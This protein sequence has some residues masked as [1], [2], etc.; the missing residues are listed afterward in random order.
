MPKYSEARK[1]QDLQFL[2]LI[3]RSQKVFPA[4]R[5]YQN[6]TTSIRNASNDAGTTFVKKLVSIDARVF[7]WCSA[8]SFTELE[9]AKIATLDDKLDDILKRML[10]KYGLNIKSS[11]NP[12]KVLGIRNYSGSLQQISN[13]D[14][15]AKENPRM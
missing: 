3:F 13:K 15:E 12:H 14:N 11:K 9:P 4:G 1:M 8:Y 6:A 10:R 7:G 2:G 5:S